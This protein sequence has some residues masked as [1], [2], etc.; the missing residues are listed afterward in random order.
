MG[1]YFFWIFCTMVDNWSIQK[2]AALFSI[3]KSLGL[4]F[5]NGSLLFFL[6]CTVVDNW[7]IQKLTEPFFQKKVCLSVCL[8]QEWVIIC[9]RIFCTMVDNWNIQKVI[10][11]F[12]SRKIH[13]CQ[14]LGKKGWKWPY[15]RVLWIL[16]KK[17]F[18][19]F[20]WK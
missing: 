9:F 12:F 15:D 4:S 8:F 18:I 17:K 7:S 16:W 6:F 10:E 13:F 19:S 2:L 11:P 1:H 20:S 5:R 3:K 14:N